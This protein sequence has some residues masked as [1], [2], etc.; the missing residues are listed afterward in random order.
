MGEWGTSVK[1]FGLLEFQQRVG[2]KI[3]TEEDEE[4]DKP[5]STNPNTLRWRRWKE[6][7]S[8]Q[9]YE[10]ILKEMREKAKKK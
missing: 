1:E 2:S 9:D 6:G 8:K 4:Y 5:F 3:P 10:D 7:K